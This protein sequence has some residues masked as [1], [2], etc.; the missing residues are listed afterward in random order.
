[1]ETYTGQ[2]A[3]EVSFQDFWHLLTREK[4]QF[5]RFLRWTGEIK[6]IHSEP[7]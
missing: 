3:E 5:L 6:S 7:K 2:N 1:M 4:R